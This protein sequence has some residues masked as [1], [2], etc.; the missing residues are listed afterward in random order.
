M[1]TSSLEP[2]VVVNTLAAKHRRTPSHDNSSSI[3]KIS[4]SQM[5]ND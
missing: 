1:G 3:N 2:S 4:F 5:E